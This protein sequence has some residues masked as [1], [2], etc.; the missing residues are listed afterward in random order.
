MDESFYEVIEF[1]SN[2]EFND[3]IFAFHSPRPFRYFTGRNSFRKDYEV[4]FP[5]YVVCEKRSESC[6]SKNI[7]FENNKYI[8][9]K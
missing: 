9:Y 1:V 5:H 8:I 2:K 7:V 4:D 6:Q 3:D